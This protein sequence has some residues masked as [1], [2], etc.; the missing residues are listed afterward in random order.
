MVLKKKKKKNSLTKFSN[1]Y[2][3]D[4]HGQIFEVRLIMGILD[5]LHVNCDHGQSSRLMRAGEKGK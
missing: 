2:N 4:D 3:Y 1:L 5:Y